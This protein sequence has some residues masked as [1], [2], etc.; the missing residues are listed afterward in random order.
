[1]IPAQVQSEPLFVKETVPMETTRSLFIWIHLMIKKE[2]LSSRLIPAGY[3]PMGFIQKHGEGAEEEGVG[4]S[5]EAG[6]PSFS[7]THR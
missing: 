1:M 2:L 7:P 6:I 5:I 3:K 4:D